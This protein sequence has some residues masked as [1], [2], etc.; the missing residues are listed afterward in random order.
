M[1][2]EIRRLLIQWRAIAAWE[3]A[4]GYLYG[5]TARQ[6]CADELE[7]A[8]LALPADRPPPEAQTEEDLSRV[9]QSTQSGPT[10]S[11]A[12]EQPKGSQR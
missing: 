5:A 9:D 3:C 2:P 11:T 4:Q 1:P 12:R 10:G 8:L 6:Q 7:A